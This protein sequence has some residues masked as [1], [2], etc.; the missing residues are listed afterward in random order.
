M[1]A[2]NKPVGP[3]WLELLKLLWALTELVGRVTFFALELCFMIL[4]AFGAM[5]AGFTRGARKGGHK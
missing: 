3:L 5:I 1:S 4:V 2:G